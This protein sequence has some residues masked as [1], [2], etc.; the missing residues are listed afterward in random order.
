MPYLYT[1]SVVKMV[2][3]FQNGRMSYL[4]SNAVVKMAVI[5]QNGLQNLTVH[6]FWSKYTLFKHEIWWSYRYVLNYQMCVCMPYI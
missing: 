1:H 5:F 4:Y 6:N 3:A 2:A